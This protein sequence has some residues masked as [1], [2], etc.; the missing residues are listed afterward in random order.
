MTPSK[1]NGHRKNGNGR[2]VMDRR[3]L[4]HLQPT[5]PKKSGP[6]PKVVDKRQIEELLQLQCTEEEIAAVIGVSVDTLQRRKRE[7]EYAE[8]WEKNRA[9][10][11]VS[12]RRL[13]RKSAN[14]SPTMQIWLGKNWLGQK[15]SLEING[16]VEV[17]ERERQVKLLARTVRVSLETGAATIEEAWAWVSGREREIYGADVEELREPVLKLVEGKREE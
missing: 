3:S 13:Q 5:G 11:K 17:F 1:Q 8:I 6:K 16:Q 7:P 14:R 15:D 9:E 12:L 4:R 10:G 2:K